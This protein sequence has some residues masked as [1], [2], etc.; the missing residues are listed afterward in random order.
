M[1]TIGWVLFANNRQQCRTSPTHAQ[2]SKHCHVRQRSPRYDL[3][4]VLCWKWVRLLARA[5]GYVW[6]VRIC[7]KP[8]SS[9]KSIHS[10]IKQMK[11]VLFA[12]VIR[13]DKCAVIFCWIFHLGKFTP[14]DDSIHFPWYFRAKCQVCIQVISSVVGIAREERPAWIMNK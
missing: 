8:G 6:L 4:S 3:L 11:H 13:N 14:C 5:F 7:S 12:V 9:I 10:D 2:Q 1:G